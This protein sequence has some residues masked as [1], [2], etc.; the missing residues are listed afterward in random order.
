MKRAFSVLLVVCLVAGTFG[1]V[2]AAEQPG[3]GTTTV[4]EADFATVQS[5]NGT[6]T[7]AGTNE[8]ASN[9]S[10]TNSTTQSDAD[11]Q[12]YIEQ[13]RHVSTGVDTQTTKDGIIYT[14]NGRVLELEP[15]NFDPADVVRAGVQED[16]ATLRFD[17]SIGRYILDTQG[18]SGTFQLMF[19]TRADGEVTTYHA[20]VQVEQAEYAHLAPGTLDELRGQADQYDWIVSQFSD[21]GLMPDDP[22]EDR[23]EAVIEDAVTWYTFY[24]NPLSGLSGQFLSF[25]IMLIK[26]PAGWV[27]LGTIFIVAFW[28]V[29]KTKKENRKL[30]RQFADIENI[31][32]SQ[33]EA[34]ERELKRILSMQT[35][36]DLGLTDSD[37]QAV[38]EHC[39][40]DNPRQFLDR[41]RDYFTPNR[42]IGLLLSAY[43]QLGH[44][45]SVQR[46][47]GQVVDA[48]L[49]DDATVPDGGVAIDAGDGTDQMAGY[50]KPSDA[51]GEII[52]ALDW[53][54]ISPDV[55]WHDDVDASK[56]D[57]PVNN[58][59]ESEGTDLVEEFGVPIGED[60]TQYHIIERREE[61]VEILVDIIEGIAASEFTDEEGRVRPD[62][63]ML[64]FL[65]TFSAVNSERYRESLW[66]VK[67]ILLR[68]RQ[69]LDAGKRMT[70]LAERSKNHELGDSSRDVG[71][72]GGEE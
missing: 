56:L 16:A 55:L 57:M 59:A 7:P 6:A 27:I 63:D 64:D 2:A 49:V 58:D 43:E 35:F 30:K 68:T 20:T 17:K 50:I 31:N 5:E 37:A 39:D 3:A 8:T 71:R 34:Q 24:D 26:W 65:Y 38:K 48:E 36:Q 15:Q 10:D 72:G 23:I 22:S 51:D 1:G 29:G 42:S 60:G 4:T 62:A 25:G 11:A 46:V 12:L 45:I 40:V 67:K 14:V 41:F 66:D 32:E 19:R 33:R 18:T 53:D 13:P 28:R 47:D 70:D 61:F 52:E 9:E 69:K 44:A 54:E 21:A